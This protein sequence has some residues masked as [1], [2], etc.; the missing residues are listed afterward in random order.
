MYKEFNMQMMRNAQGFTIVEVMVALAILFIGLCGIL[1]QWP[2]GVDLVMLSGHRSEAAVLAE[3]FLE[4]VAALDFP[5]AASLG[6]GTRYVHG[7]QMDYV[8][9]PGPV[10]GSLSAEIQVSWV[11]RA[12]THYLHM[13]TIIASLL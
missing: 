2:I 7:F 11:H 13:G 5:A 4:E 3:R 6:S 8:V 9:S 1:I 12:Q 10:E